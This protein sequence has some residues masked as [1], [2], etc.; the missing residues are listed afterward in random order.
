METLI[1]KFHQ[2]SLDELYQILKLRVDVFVVEQNCAYPEIDDNDQDAMHLF[3]KSDH[4]VKAYLRILKTEET[5]AK[6]GRVVTSDDFR[7]NGSSRAL[8][9]E[10]LQI[11]RNDEKTTSVVLQA[12]DYLTG[13]YASFGFEKKSDIYLEDGIPHVDMG[14]V[15]KTK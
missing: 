11:L 4:R 7:G 1:K 9:A 15:L 8:M 12:Q 14:L 13:F 6:I 5:A 2:L 10:A 3:I